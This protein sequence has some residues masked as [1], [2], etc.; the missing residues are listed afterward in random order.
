MRQY[1]AITDN[2]LQDV[3]LNGNKKLEVSKNK[4]GQEEPPKPVLTPAVKRTQEKALN[5]LLFAIP[6]GHLLNLHDAK[7]AKELWDAIKVRFGGNEASKKMHRNMLKQQFQTFT[8]GERE[9]LH[10]AY[11]R[12]QNLLSMLELYGAEVTTEDANLKFLRSF[13]SIW[14]VVATMI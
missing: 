4:D 9:T 7:D 3:I 14:H 13:P 12:F 6:D 11:H 2:S 5:I 1:I 10:A 8:I